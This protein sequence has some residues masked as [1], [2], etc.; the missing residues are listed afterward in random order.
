MER[1]L[2]VQHRCRQLLTSD[3]SRGWYSAPDRAPN[4]PPEEALCSPH[5][6]GGRRR[7]VFARHGPHRQ[8]NE[9]VSK[10]YKGNGIRT[11]KYSLLTFIPM[12]LFEQ[13]HRSVSDPEA[14]KLNVS[15]IVQ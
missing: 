3:P 7:T 2:W 6:V 11:T 1:L 8:E 4:K 13:F 12:N 9:V 15:L 10:N 14:F 5:R